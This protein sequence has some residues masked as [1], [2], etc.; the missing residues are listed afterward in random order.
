TVKEGVGKEEADEIKGKLE[1]AGAAV[2]VK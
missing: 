1:E 2:E